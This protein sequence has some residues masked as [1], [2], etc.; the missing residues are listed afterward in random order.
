MFG[1]NGYAMLVDEGGK[2]DKPNKKS[3]SADTPLQLATENSMD[4]SLLLLE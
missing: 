4:K 3:C 1:E 2:I